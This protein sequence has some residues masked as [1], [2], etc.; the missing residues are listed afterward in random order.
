MLIKMGWSTFPSAVRALAEGR[1][2]L[3]VAPF[4]PFQFQP[5]AMF[6][7]IPSRAAREHP[8]FL[9][10]PYRDLYRQEEVG[11]PTVVRFL[12]QVVAVVAQLPRGGPRNALIAAALGDD[13]IW[14]PE[15][16][17]AQAEASAR[18]LYVFALSVY[19]ADRPYTLERAITSSGQLGLRALEIGT[20][21]PLLPLRDV[22]AHAQAILARVRA[23]SAPP[24]AGRPISPAP[25]PRPASPAFSPVAPSRPPVRSSDEVTSEL[26]H[27]RAETLR[28]R[29]ERDQ[30]TAQVEDLKKLVTALQ[31]RIAEL[32]E[33][34]A[35]MRAEKAELEQALEDLQVEAEERDAQLA[36]ALTRVRELE[37]RP[38]RRT[39][40][41]PA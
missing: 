6:W 29:H 25:A 11:G 18:D 33:E 41:A 27:L 30:L 40:S 13:L 36:Q 31:E 5:D 20:P 7:L 15:W 26:E 21:Q 19:Q 8:D 22:Q 39:P 28:L 14:T 32:E 38:G 1:T 9:K 37:Q 34:N 17:L 3:G 10:P 23:G 24:A 35:Q 4:V 12:G 2:I 16:L